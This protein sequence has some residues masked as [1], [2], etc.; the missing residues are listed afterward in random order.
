[1]MNYYPVSRFVISVLF[2]FASLVLLCCGVMPTLAAPGDL[3]PLFGTGGKVTTPVGTGRDLAQAVA[4]QSD[5]KIIVVGYAQSDFAIVRDLPN[6]TL[7]TSFG[8]SGT[9]KVLTPIGSAT[10]DEAYAVAVQ[11][12]GKIVAAGFTTNAGNRDFAV[13]RYLSNGTLDPTF[14]TG[15]KVI[16]PVGTGD[17]LAEAVVVQPDGKIIVAGSSTFVFALVRYNADG[18]LDTGF[19]TGGKTLFSVS[20]SGGLAHSVALQADGAILVGGSSVVNV[21]QSGLDKF[22][23]VRFAPNG[24][25]DNT[26][27]TGG[28]RYFDQCYPLRRYL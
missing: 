20:T 25:V 9:G 5:G 2:F 28:S 8:T 14:G 15:G 16:T 27:G 21:G 10:P 1:M 7:D 4:L 13:V 6:G 19:G 11:T 18:S 26:F 24:T 12:D 22:T 3:D 23:L 17:D